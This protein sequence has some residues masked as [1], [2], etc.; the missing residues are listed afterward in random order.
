M[1][2][3]VFTGKTISIYICGKNSFCKRLYDQ[4]KEKEKKKRSPWISLTSNSRSLGSW[5][6]VLIDDELCPAI[7]ALR[8]SESKEN[9]NT[10]SS[11]K[12]ILE[13]STITPSV[14]TLTVTVTMYNSRNTVQ[15]TIQY[16]LQNVN[17]N[18]STEKI[19]ETEDPLFHEIPKWR[20]KQLRR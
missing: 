15:L 19:K 1:T 10:D 9:T 5:I 4:E 13:I 20:R 2:K 8:Y 18:K 3:K 7:A 6:S 11:S 14:H 17:K 12:E 16:P